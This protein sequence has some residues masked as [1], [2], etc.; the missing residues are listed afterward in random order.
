MISETAVRAAVEHGLDLGVLCGHD[1]RYQAELAR[2]LT[3]LIPSAELVRFTGSGTE[4]AWHATRFAGPGPSCRLAT[5]TYQF[6]SLLE[7]PQ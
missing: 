6:T 4:T 1:T 7:Q 5:S 2:R 3:E